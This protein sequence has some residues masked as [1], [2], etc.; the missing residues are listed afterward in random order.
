M[1]GVVILNWNN[2]EDTA[3]ALHSCARLGY[4]VKIIVVD[5]GSTDDS[6]KRIEKNFPWVEL[7][8]LPRN[9][10]FAKANN[11]ALKYLDSLKYEF[12]LLMNNDVIIESNNLLDVLLNVMKRDK[13]VAV[14][15]PKIHGK[16][17][18]PTVKR[19]SL[20]QYVLSPYMNLIISRLYPRRLREVREGPVYT[21][22]GC[23]MLVRLSAM[24][25]AGW[26]DENTF[27]YAEEAILA[28]RLGR[29]GFKMYYCPRV[30][31]YHKGGRTTGRKR[32]E[33]MKTKVESELYYFREYRG[34]GVIR[35]S[36]VLVSLWILYYLRLIW[37]YLR[38][39][40]QFIIR[41]RGNNYHE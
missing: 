5:N 3:E 25:A 29:N 28:E 33:S 40:T 22:S 34:F 15:G 10:G 27:L 35:L 31:V 39:V 8:R 1:I 41:L 38:Q 18:P 21:V 36:I 9:I 14:I 23:C 17:S 24:R 2:Y 19:M 13:D 32:H 4:N 20:L 16:I 12:A 30:S 11:V 26:F 7:L 37:N 6:P